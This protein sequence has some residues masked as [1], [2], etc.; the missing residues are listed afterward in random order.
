MTVNRRPKQFSDFAGCW[1][2]RQAAARSQGGSAVHRDYNLVACNRPPA[3]VED[4]QRPC[5][6]GK[7]IMTSHRLHVVGRGVVVASVLL[8]PAVFAQ[9]PDPQ[10]LL[11]EADRL[12]WLT[13]WHDALPIYAEV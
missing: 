1:P 6:P 7:V 2:C 13:N 11:A 5:E 3:E 12:A 10:K 4:R 9:T 8:C